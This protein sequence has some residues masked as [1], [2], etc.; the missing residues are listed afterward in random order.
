MKTWL[1]IVC[2]CASVGTAS[3]Q[4]PGAPRWPSEGPP[5][6]LAA[7]EVK[8]PPY[9]VRTLD[10]GLQVVAVLHH[11][12]PVVSM[13]M[14]VRAGAALDP[15]DKAGLANLAAS[16]LDQGTTTQSASEMNDAIDF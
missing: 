11:E 8:F 13:R 1:P 12:Q 9:E 15:K 6:P 14:L 5:R 2:L 3:A 10:N 7:R 4:V 16:L